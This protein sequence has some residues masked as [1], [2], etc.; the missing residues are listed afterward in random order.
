VFHHTTLHTITREGILYDTTAVRRADAQQ[1][2][3]IRVLFRDFCT[4]RD[5]AVRRGA[6]R[7]AARGRVETFL[8]R[9]RLLAA[10]PGAR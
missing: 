7:K 9:Y 6:S 8:R 5:Y 4:H 1:R 2:D 10:D 3:A